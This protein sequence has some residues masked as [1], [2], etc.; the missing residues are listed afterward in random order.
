MQRRGIFRKFQAERHR[1]RVLQPGARHHGRV[2]MFS[3]EPG[4]AR[5]G[6]VEIRQQ[7]VD[8]G[9]Q[10]QHGRGVDHVLAGGA[11]VHIARGVR[12]GLCDGSGKRLHQRDCEIAASR[13][14]LG[15]RR[16]IKRLGPAGL[17]DRRC[18]ACRNHTCRRLGARERRLEIEHVL[19]IGRIVADR[20]H[21]GAGEQRCEEGR[22]GGA[23]AAR[24]LTIPACRLPMPNRF[25]FV[26]A[27]L[28]PAI[29]VFFDAPP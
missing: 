20:A 29:H 14:G 11:P 21:G 6:A 9:A 8:R 4:K 12:V 5:D 23:H 18:R 7:R 13:R 15:Q 1:Q 2:A 26:M 19:Q 25:P 28:V 10:G 22:Q 16:D 3:R 27:G 24:D 17:R